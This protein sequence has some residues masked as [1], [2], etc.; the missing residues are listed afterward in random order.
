MYGNVKK[1][2]KFSD[3]KAHD[4]LVGETGFFFVESI[5]KKNKKI[6]IINCQTC[7]HYKV[8]FSIIKN[9]KKQNGINEVG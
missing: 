8:N 6:C 5:D 4:L 1:V 2:M 3:I 9:L 7:E